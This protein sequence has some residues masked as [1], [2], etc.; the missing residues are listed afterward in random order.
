M[1]SVN[2]LFLT[3]SLGYPREELGSA[4]AIDV[5]PYKV[6]SMLKKKNMSNNLNLFVDARPGRDTSELVKNRD[7]HIKAYQPDVILLQVGIVDCY[8]RALTKAEAMILP[9]LPFIS[10]VSKYIVKKY[11]SEI[12]KFRNISYVNKVDFKI[13]LEHLRDGFRNTKWIVIPI[14]PVNSNYKESN[15]LIEQR[16]QE[17]NCLLESVFGDMY[18]GDFYNDANVEDLYLPDNHHLCLKGHEFVADKAY[19]ILVSNCNDLHLLC[20][21]YLGSE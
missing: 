8:S 15:P 1:L 19:D 14:G 21:G 17:Y 18:L 2:V 16:V 12:V 4:K 5:W 6:S 10:R 11:Y 7:K 3:D 13:N 20:G 9:R